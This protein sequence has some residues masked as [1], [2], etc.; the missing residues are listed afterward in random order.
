MSDYCKSYL[1]P[2]SQRYRLN[3]LKLYMIIEVN[4]IL[5]GINMWKKELYYLCQLESGEVVGGVK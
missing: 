4:L 5:S 2:L 1:I 3:G